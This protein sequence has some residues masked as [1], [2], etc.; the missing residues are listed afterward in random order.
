MLG[1]TQLESSLAEKDL[2]VL[3]DSRLTVSHQCALA[4]KAADDKL[5]CIRRTVVNRLSK[6]I[7]PLSSALVRPHLEYYVQLW[8]SQYKRDMDILERVLKDDEG[9]GVSLL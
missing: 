1:A 8:A 3:V 4:A 7:H 5:G 6:R 2:G 9:F